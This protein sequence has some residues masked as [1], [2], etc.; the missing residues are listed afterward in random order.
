[1]KAIHFVLL[2]A[3]FSANPLLCQKS[4]YFS[5][6]GKTITLPGGEPVL[7]KG[8]NLGNWLVP[9]GYMFKF[10]AATSP[11]KVNEVICELIGPD[12]AKKFWIEFQDN[13][14][15]G[16]DIKYLKQLGFNHI[17][18]PFNYLLF[19]EDTYLQNSGQRGF[20]LFDKLIGWCREANMYILLD[21]H[22]APGGQTGDN[23]DDSFG[24]PWLFENEESQQLAVDIWESIAERYS[25]EE[26]LIGYDLLNEPIAHYFD[27]DKLSPRLE[28]L[29][30]RIVEAIR[31]HDNNHLIFLGGAR[32]N[33]NF[34]VFGEPFDDKLV[35]TFHKYWMP[36]EQKEIQEYV[37]F[38]NKYNVPLYMGESGENEDE[39]INDFRTL[40]EQN[41]IGWGFWPYKKM[42]SPRGVVQFNMPDNYDAIITYA[43]GDHESYKS[44]RKNRPDYDVVKKALEDFIELSKLK[45]CRLNKEYVKALGLKQ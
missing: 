30:K 23:I 1:M 17:R 26:I 36:T 11:R 20:E 32:W 27:M 28:P 8:I 10:K 21:M 42:D 24:Y 18:L 34:S 40:L 13:Y 6:E 25:D 31:K 41:N 16:E 4:E 5:V 9:E 45:N 29:Y 33:T 43:N 35:Y 37:D 2:L 22:C 14:I 15:T 19:T 44:I 12:R 39:W 7:L 3:I 38:S